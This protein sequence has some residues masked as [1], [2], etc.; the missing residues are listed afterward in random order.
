MLRVARRK[1]RERGIDGRMALQQEDMR[2]LPAEEATFDAVT[3]SFG[4][5]NVKERER[6]LRECYRVLKP[7]GRLFVMEP[8]ILDVPVLGPL[9]RFYFDHVMPLV[10]NLLSGTDYA[11][12]YLS[13]TVYAFPTAGD[14]V[15]AFREAGFVD[16]MALPVSDGLARIYR[17][18]KPAD[19]KR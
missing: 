14:F 10:G 16:S 19:G 12:T 7:G 15:S 3:I 9:Y 17:G 13:E 5:R 2:E 6:V 4:I 18:R 1:L 8:G 11:Y